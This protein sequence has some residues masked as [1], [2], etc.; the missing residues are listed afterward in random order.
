MKFNLTYFVNFSTKKRH[1]GQS[2]AMQS[3]IRKVKRLD[4]EIIDEYFEKAC[5]GILAVIIIM[6]I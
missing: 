6:I 3:D 1:G 4:G 2:G 5:R